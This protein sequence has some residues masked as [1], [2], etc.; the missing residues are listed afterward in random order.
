M[1]KGHLEFAYWEMLLKSQKSPGVLC[2]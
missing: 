1:S 2:D